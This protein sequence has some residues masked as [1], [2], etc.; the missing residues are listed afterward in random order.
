MRYV[1]LIQN[2]ING[3]VYVGQTKNFSNRKAGHLYSAKKGDL[4]PL[5]CSI[6]KYGHENFEFRIL[7]ECDDHECD[8]REIY[9]I[10]H[11]DSF[12]IDRGYNLTRGGEGSTGCVVSIE[13][14]QKMSDKH[15][16]KPKSLEHRQAISRA[17]L[18]WEGLRGA[19]NPNFGTHL[20]DQARKKIS[21]HAKLRIGVKNP[22]CSLTEDDVKGIKYQLSIGTRVCDI[23]KLFNISRSQVNR[24]KLNKQWK[25]VTIE[26]CV[27][28]FV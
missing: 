24:I 5:Y 26:L 6:R 28:I 21:E 8:D 17:R 25:H 9:W 1:Y 19:R 2:L 23:V 18:G 14:R 3:K 11:Y 12:N 20:T 22:N 15:R 7:E 4:R 10:S 16:G 27:L 13:T